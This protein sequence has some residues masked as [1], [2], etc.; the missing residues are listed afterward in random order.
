MTTNAINFTINLNGNAYEASVE[1]KDVI[2]QIQKEVNGAQNVFN[3]LGKSAL[4]FD[5][6]S[7][8]VG[9][10]ANGFQT[11]VGPALEYEKTL[12]NLT[13]L[14]N[15][16]EE[17]AQAMFDRLKDYGAATSY[18]LGGLAE[19]QKTMMAFGIEG[20]KA[21]GVLKQIGDIAMGDAQ[22]M[23]ALSLAFAQ[24]S[25]TGK[26]TGQDLLQMINAGFNP[27]EV[28]SQKT[29]ISMAELKDQMS[30][31]AITADMVAQSFA[32]ATSEGGRFQN[33]AAAA[34]E[35]V[36]GKIDIIKG[37]IDDFKYSLFEATNGATAYI[38]E[39]GA[40]LVPIA[41]LFPL[42]TGVGKA[43]QF[44]TAN[45][46]VFAKFVKKQAMHVA[47]S[48]V[49]MRDRWND[50]V[51]KVNTGT[52]NVLGKLGLI[53]VGC[54]TTGIFITGLGKTAE[55]TSNVITRAIYK[56]PIIGWILAIIGAVIAVISA[57]VKL[58]KY[59]WNEC[60]G[61]R[62]LL[63]GVWEVLKTVFGAIWDVV[64]QVWNRISEGAQ[65]LWN[66]LVDGVTFVVDWFVEKWNSII[67]FFTRVWTRIAEGAQWLWNKLVDGVTFVVD[68]FVDVWNTAGNFF[69]GL[70]EWICLAFNS[71]M[72][73]I[74]E[75]LGVVGE[76]FNKYIVEPVSKAFD[77]VWGKVKEVVDK[78]KNALK[79]A[80]GSVTDL[81]NKITGKVA[82]AYQ[83]G[84]EKGSE[85][86]RKDQEKKA[87]EN[88]TTIPEVKVDEDEK[89]ETGTLK[90]PSFNFNTDNKLSGGSMGSQADSGISIQCDYDFTYDKFVVFKQTALD[91]V[92][93]VQSETK[94]NIWFENKVLHIHPV[95]SE[96][97][98]AKPIIFD[99]RINVQ[100]NDLKWIDKSNKKVKVEVVFI[101]PDGTKE[102]GEFGDEGGEKITKH[103]SGSNSS[104]LKSLA[105]NEYNLW[106]YSGFEGN[107]TSWLI[108]VV[109]SGD[110]VLLRDVNQPEGKYYVT[111]VEVEFGQNGGK[112]KISL[113]RRLG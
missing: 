55:K 73:W 24:T 42:L 94:A 86:F 91:A 38:A 76:W 21:F 80:V 15:G 109:H 54:T 107:F 17:A 29:G 108:P 45:F 92:K 87:K 49:F 34:A 106:N 89:D 79:S 74:R 82:D 67:D 58:F 70:W 64:K 104:E 19:S 101:K 3:K 27:L 4:H 57:I 59:L 14:Y 47:I 103:V 28:I 18:D 113:G 97:S 39:I 93:K 2:K 56:I 83:E 61:F 32:A 69:S 111:G 16:N 62:R 60:E 68:W 25:S 46:G 48:F 65:W 51:K 90:P 41:D 11:L 95:Y 5:A 110:T 35:T 112:R 98:D 77:K 63:F 1:L 26:L 75:K 44:T 8:V 105:E 85:S 71:A 43:I 13:T 23:Q 81:W 53:N 88:E 37:N 6:I 102:K 22:K 66:K 30:K 84:A 33:G 20:E 40:M 12:S 78:V 96:K 100:K 72:E 99:T 9:N 50:F 7:N 31:G 36:A 10:I 52:V